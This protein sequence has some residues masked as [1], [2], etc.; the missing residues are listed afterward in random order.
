MTLRIAKRDEIHPPP[1]GVK[2]FAGQR[3]R[4]SILDRPPL[5]KGK[6]GDL[7]QAMLNFFTLSLGKGGRSYFLWDSLSPILRRLEGMKIS[8]YC[9]P[10]WSKGQTYGLDDELFGTSFED[11]AGSVGMRSTLQQHR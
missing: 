11:T 9:S 6:R 7:F 2:E 10:S 4:S 8:L 5:E 1:E 3:G